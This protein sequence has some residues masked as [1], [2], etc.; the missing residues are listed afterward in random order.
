MR[1]GD[2]GCGG[3]CGGACGGDCGCSSGG[4]CGGRSGTDFHRGLELRGEGEGSLLA[5]APRS[6]GEPDGG[7]HGLAWGGEGGRGGG[8]DWL[9]AQGP[10]PGSPGRNRRDGDGLGAVPGRPVQRGTPPWRWDDFEGNLWDPPLGDWPHP[11]W[12]NQT[13]TTWT[14]I[15]TIEQD[16]GGSDGCPEICL[17]RYQECRTC[18]ENVRDVPPEHADEMRRLCL[19]YCDAYAQCLASYPH[20]EVRDC[21]SVPSIPEDLDLLCCIKIKCAP[22][23]VLPVAHHCFFE[24]KGCWEDTPHRYELWQWDWLSALSG[25][26]PRPDQKPFPGQ[27][28]IVKDFGKVGGGVGG[29]PSDTVTVIEEC[30]QCEP[31][32]EI[33]DTPCACL[34]R[35]MAAYEYG[36]E[37]NLPPHANSNTF[38]MYVGARCGLLDPSNPFPVAAPGAVVQPPP[39]ASDAGVIVPSG[40]SENFRALLR[41]YRD[42]RRGYSRYRSS[43][44]PDWR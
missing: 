7:H 20:Y 17:R 8:D 14:D 42:A 5:A 30:Y 33:A 37:Y 15:G 44:R 1:N 18:L 24:V 32:G 21:P 13:T 23:P 2:C 35:E 26:V 4:S 6:S 16:E 40:Y 22:I 39:I 11:D 36:N 9:G 43:R 34:M 27:S 25:G 10:R 3:S 38:A 41:A 12:S 19:F 29:P 28:R 31:A